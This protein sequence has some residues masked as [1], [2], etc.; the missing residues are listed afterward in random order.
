MG[1]LAKSGLKGGIPKFACSGHCHT[2]DPLWPR[3]LSPFALLPFG[4]IHLS[5][6]AFR[7]TPFQSA[8]NLPRQG[9]EDGEDSRKEAMPGEE[10]VDPSLLEV[11]P[12]GF[13]G[14]YFAEGFD[15]CLPSP[16]VGFDTVA[17]V[18]SR[19]S[20]ETDL[21][22]EVVFAGAVDRD[23][24]HGT[25]GAEQAEAF[26]HG[27]FAEFETRDEIVKGQGLL[28]A[29]K[30]AVNFPQGTGKRENGKGPDEEVDGFPL[31]GSEG[32]GRGEGQGGTR[33][34]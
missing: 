17:Q 15:P 1:S 22:G 8:S 26:A 11:V 3:S 25:K 27:T 32:L 19:E 23:E 6:Y 10:L 29:I 28:T 7:L 30:Q 31:E 33:G 34:Y 5:P 4:L 16:E 2:H 13:G 9:L 20:S 24:V 21:G 12:L 14:A 18:A